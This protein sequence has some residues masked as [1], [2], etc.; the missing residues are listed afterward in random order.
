MINSFSKYIRRLTAALLMC[1][2]LLSGCA[3]PAEAPAPAETPEP[4]EESPVQVLP[5]PQKIRISEYMAKNRAVIH[6]ENGLFSDWIEL[7]NYSEEDILLSGWH[8]S[9]SR[10]EEGTL[11]PDTL[12]P[13]GGFLLV[14]ASGNEGGEGFI[15][16]GFSL[17]EGE[18]ICLRDGYG[19]II[20]ELSSISAEADVS[21]VRNADG[22]FEKSSFSTPG[23]ENSMAGYEAWQQSRVCDSP[24]I[25]YEAM[26]AN[27]SCLKQNDGEYY[28]WVEI[29]NISSEPI[30]LSDYYLSDDSD[31][32]LQWRFPQRSLA[33][34]GIITVICSG[35]GTAASGAFTYSTFSLAAERDQL[36]LSDGTR[37]LDYVSLGQ[38]PLNTS[39]GRID[40]QNGFWHFKN[41]S[42]AAPNG[43]YGY[44][45]VSQK[46]VSLTADGVFD[47]VDSISVHLS[48]PGDIYYSTDGSMPTLSSA[49]YEGPIEITKTTVLRAINVQE[50]FMPSGALTQSF[51][52]NEGHSLP[53][54]SLVTDD[55]DRFNFL[56]RNGSKYTTVPGCLSLYEP[57]G[58]FTI[59]CGVK[60]SGATS[61]RLPKRN[62]SVKFRARY[63]QSSLEYDVFDGGVSYFTDLTIRAGQDHFTSMIRNELCQELCLDFSEATPTQRSKFCV[64]YLNGAYWGIYVLKDKINEQFYASIAGVSEESVTLVD[65]PVKSSSSFYHD[66]W[67]LC[68]YSDMS[69]DENYDKLCQVLDIDSLIDWLIMEG[70]SAN[71]DLYSGNVRYC[72]SDENDGKW[73]VVFYDLDCGFWHGNLNFYNLLAEAARPQQ[74]SQILI[75]LLENEDFRHRFLLRFEEAINGPLSNESVLAK[76]DELQ[77]LIYPE[78]PRN[79]ERW[80]MSMSRWER[81]VNNIRFLINE[82][83]WQQYNINTVCKIFK[84]TEEERLKYF[85]Q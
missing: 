19:R 82:Y 37:L 21:C 84:L 23:F 53:V 83:D 17:S 80:G 52:V 15:H 27:S 78:M 42:P 39:Y 60:L 46:P 29:K 51:I 26:N 25:I 67:K 24:L 57:D 31:D 85:G 12:I 36:Y 33:P 8:I 70:V 55:L 3:A 14:F 11:L 50:G 62:L 56:Y 7:E 20:Q 68:G 81:N 35:S 43:S 34:G 47:G 2:L 1:A 30:E 16:A 28:D 75:P 41:P 4:E 13:A 40:G 61:L 45:L 10:E 38:L 63:G 72:R 54:L 69:L 18:S 44:R 77:Q 64:L 32:M 59:D 74:I 22:S 49:R 6:D 76:I 79:C 9:D 48:A 58:S 65:G 73:R 71:S 5:E 66:V